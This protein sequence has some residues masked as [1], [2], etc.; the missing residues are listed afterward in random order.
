[1]Q[2]AVREGNVDGAAA[3]E[4][5][6]V[7]IDEAAASRLGLTPQQAIGQTIIYEKK[8]HLHI[9][10]VLASAKVWWRARACQAAVYL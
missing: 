1:M 2:D 5:H 8:S 3:N 6:N 4:G 10:G 9:V 7:L